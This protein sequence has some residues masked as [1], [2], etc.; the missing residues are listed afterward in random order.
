G[1]R[2]QFF[3]RIKTWGPGEGRDP[4][5]RT[6]EH[7]TGLRR[8][9]KLERLPPCPGAWATKLQR[10]RGKAAELALDH[11][12]EGDRR[13]ILQKAADD[14]HADR[15]TTLAASDRRGRRRQPG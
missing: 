9:P 1:D 5:F 7:L 10:R 11:P 15:Q 8:D 13:A 6:H 3:R 2:A 4:C 14:L 12:G